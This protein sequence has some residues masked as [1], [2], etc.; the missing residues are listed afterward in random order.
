V[1]CLYPF[2]NHY[3]TASLIASLVESLPQDCSH[4]WY[5]GFVTNKRRWQDIFIT[6][7]R[8][9]KVRLELNEMCRD[10]LN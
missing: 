1:S 9:K 3:L 10:K 8:T 6:W 2:F 4:N 7:N 5:N